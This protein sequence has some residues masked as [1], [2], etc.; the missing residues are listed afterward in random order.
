MRQAAVDVGLAST[1][2]SEDD[3]ARLNEGRAQW[4]LN[5]HLYN[6]NVM[7][8]NTPLGSGLEIP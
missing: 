2:R 5:A 8:T 6:I 4:A 7:R 1:S 3:S